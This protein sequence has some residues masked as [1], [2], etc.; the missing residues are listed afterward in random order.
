MNRGRIIKLC[1]GALAAAA[2]VFTGYMLLRE[3]DIEADKGNATEV[4]AELKG[5]RFGTYDTLRFDCEVKITDFDTVYEEIE[6]G[7]RGDDNT[8][9]PDEIKECAADMARTLYGAEPDVILYNYTDD[10]DV[11]HASY[12]KDGILTWYYYN[13]NFSAYNQKNIRWASPALGTSP[14]QM[15]SLEDKMVARFKPSDNIDDVVYDINGEQYS[16]KDAIAFTDKK[17]SE[18]VNKYFDEQKPLLTDMGVMYSPTRKT[19]TYILKYSHF[20]EGVLIDDTF[21]PSPDTDF[22]KGSALFVELY[23]KDTIS[24]IDNVGY[25][26]ITGKKKASKIIPLSEAERLAVEGLAPGLGYIVTE[27]E[28][29]YVCVTNQ[30]TERPVCRPMWVFVM[31]G[32]END[33]EYSRGLDNF[34]KTKLFIDAVTGKSMIYVPHYGLT[35]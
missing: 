12:S 10:G 17:L 14:E 21:D 3:K 7:W 31:N 32:Y 27:C 16:L 5:Y 25:F 2:V 35:R 26:N 30:E 34:K 20:V 18:S 28:L 24:F 1:A 9:T 19:Y 8:K 22:L 13:S 33:E 29:K 4:A 15:Q 11:P 6:T 23:E